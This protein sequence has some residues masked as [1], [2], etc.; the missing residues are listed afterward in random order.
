MIVVG[1]FLGNGSQQVL[2]YDHNVGGGDVVGFYPSGNVSLDSGWPN[3]WDM[4]VAGDFVGT[5]K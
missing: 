1:D 2:A 4:L 5:G 3:S